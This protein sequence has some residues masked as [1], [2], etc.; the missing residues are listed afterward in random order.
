[1]GDAALKGVFKVG[2]LRVG[3]DV[4]LCP[5][6]G[7]TS[8]NH[9]N[10]GKMNINALAFDVVVGDLKR[11]A[12]GREHL[13]GAERADF[14]VTVRIIGHEPEIVRLELHRLAIKRE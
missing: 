2:I 4:E 13:V 14:V 6:F 9:F 7:I 3:H 12:P 5:R 11:V 8:G 1:M 10:A